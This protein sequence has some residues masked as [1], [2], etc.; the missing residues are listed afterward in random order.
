[1]SKAFDSIGM[2]PLRHAFHRIKLPSMAI[3]FIINLFQHRKMKIIINFG[4]NMMRL[5]Y[6]P[7]KSEILK[8]I[9]LYCVTYFTILYLGI[10]LA[11]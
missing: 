6:K 4:L 11:A 9:Y 3:D 10:I 1:M 2:T 7:Q 5:I 8:Y